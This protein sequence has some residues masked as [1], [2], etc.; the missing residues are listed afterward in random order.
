MK[1][2]ALTVAWRSCTDFRNEDRMLKGFY[3]LKVFIAL[4]LVF[5]AAAYAQDQHQAVQQELEQVKE[6]MRQAGVDPDQMEQLD[7]IMGQIGEQEAARREARDAEGNPEYEELH[8]NFGIAV[9]T[10]DGERFE[11]DV[12]RCSTQDLNQGLFAIEALRG[13]DRDNGHLIVNGTG[14]Y[15]PS[16]LTY[17][18]VGRQYRVG[19]ASFAFDGQR[20]EWSGQVDGPAG[21]SAFE[22]S[23]TCRANDVAASIT[24][25][26]H[27]GAASTSQKSSAPFSFGMSGLGNPTIRVFGMPKAGADNSNF[28]G[29]CDGAS[30]EDDIEVMSFTAPWKLVGA[31][32]GSLLVGGHALDFE[33]S[34]EFPR[35]RLTLSF[36]SVSGVHDLESY[37]DQYGVVAEIPF[38]G[39]TV[40]LVFANETGNF[41]FGYNAIFPVAV[42]EG[43]PA[44]PGQNERYLAHVHFGPIGP[45]HFKGWPQAEIVGVFKS[46]VTAPCTGEGLKR[47]YGPL[48]PRVIYE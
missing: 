18:E 14:A 37:I 1:M 22:V 26:R 12:I 43:M 16:T 29:D 10:I 35:K 25:A 28:P 11:L 48:N 8:E 6:M 9:V 47:D 20:L 24:T 15:A 13:P 41:K 3:S 5:G 4:T 44:A 36:R 45:L 30:P 42:V 19:D 7:A 27:G 38:A 46:L 33:R 2:I 17:S 32:G 39:N 23:L 40:K 31:S 34:R 21:Q